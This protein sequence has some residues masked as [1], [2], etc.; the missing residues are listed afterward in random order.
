[1]LRSFLR[2]ILILIVVVGIVAFFIGYWSGQ[3]DGGAGREPV[4]GTSGT[5]R[6]APGVNVDTARKTGAE[7]GERV[8]EGAN[9]AGRLVNSAAVT[10]KIKAKMALDDSVKAA[11]IDV[12]T[13]GTVVTLSGTVHSEAERARALQLA[14]ETD[15]VTSVVDHLQVR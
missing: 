7:V 6:S 10:S 8:A 3:P 2:L 4:A 5:E 11:A 9:E 12:D 14:R 13:S 1:M 15:G